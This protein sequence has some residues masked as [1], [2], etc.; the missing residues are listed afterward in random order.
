M[1][2]FIGMISLLWWNKRRLRHESD[3]LVLS[4]LQSGSP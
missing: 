2:I 3:D 4:F 1:W